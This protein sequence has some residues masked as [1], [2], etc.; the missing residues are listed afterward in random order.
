MQILREKVRL[1]R[2]WLAILPL[3][4][5]LGGCSAA[6]QVEG[7]AYAVTMA[8]DAAETGEM[9]V[10]VQVPS[11]GG[12]AKA[13]GESDDGGYVISSATGAN[14]EAALSLL[15]ETIPRM[16][17]LSQIKSLIIAEELARRDDF[18]MFLREIKQYH[19]LYGE[20]GLIICQ[21]SARDMLEQQK[22]LIGVRLSDSVV[23]A[24][25]QY[26]LLGTI[27]RVTLATA[28]YASESVY[29][30][31]IAVLAAVSGAE[32]GADY[33]GSL[34]RTGDNRE[35][36]YGGALLKDG[37]MVGRLSGGE[38]QL[39]NL[40]RGADQPM[41][42]IVDGVAMNL[43]RQGPPAVSVDLRGGVPVIDVKLCVLASMTDAPFNPDEIASALA[44]RYDALTAH[45]QSLGVDPFG[46]ARTAAAQFLTIPDWQAYDWHE[47]F[48]NARVAY[49]ITLQRTES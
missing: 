38:M 20:A 28:L 33:A 6:R 43:E 14:F 34:D 9:T 1:M 5:L 35:E 44:T 18:G 24:L 31:P 19:L 8:V 29:E 15:N 41:A 30:D 21:G 48:K 49:A 2:R 36:Y 17:N 32:T 26:S 12:A 42:M 47:R 13:D 10:S 11:L 22:A 7:Q 40:L 3:I 45:C 39:M 27:P 46:Y 25:E 16:L 37:H 4:F 23:I